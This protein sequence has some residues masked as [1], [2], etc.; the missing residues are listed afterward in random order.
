MTANQI[1]IPIALI[2]FAAFV[3]W[4]I[5][6]NR[7]AKKLDEIQGHR[8]NAPPSQIDR[9]AIARSVAEGHTLGG[10]QSQ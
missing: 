8:S 9:G 3:V 10:Q 2:G 5:A 6:T 4:L 7:R 1:I